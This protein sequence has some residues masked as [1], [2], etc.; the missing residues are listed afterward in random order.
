MKEEAAGL[1]GDVNNDNVV[2]ITDVTTLISA[3]MTE[4]FA[5]IN[6]TNAD[7]NGDNTINITDV[8]MLINKVM[9]Q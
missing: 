8:T 6:T 2:N 1:V 3:V 9:V 4:N 7:L 5:N